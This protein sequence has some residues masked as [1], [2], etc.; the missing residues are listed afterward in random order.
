MG[1]YTFK[2]TTDPAI[3]AAAGEG[4]NRH[5]AGMSSV[6]G[7]VIGINAHPVLSHTYQADTLLHE[8]LHCSYRM[9][10]YEFP[11]A[12]D[13]EKAVLA[14][15]TSLLSCLRDNPRVVEFLAHRE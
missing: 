14:A 1:P 10:G 9:S 4:G 7:G 8:L 12:E 6:E 5:I 3:L 2:V 15:A 11:S 13:E